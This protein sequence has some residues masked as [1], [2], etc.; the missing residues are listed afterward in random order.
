[1]ALEMLWWSANVDYAEPERI[2]RA[3]I[4][5]AIKLYET[6]LAPMARRVY[7]EFSISDDQHSIRLLANELIKRQEE[8]LNKRDVY[9]RWGLKGLDTA[10]RVGVAI[11]GLVKAG[12]VRRET[13]SP[14]AEGGRRP[15]NF[16]VNPRLF[17]N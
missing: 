1:L 12:W 4:D 14:G 2:S 16:L 3:A 10:T 15:E 9:V 11:E 17:Q 8:K 7:G 6:Y 13:Y 5:M